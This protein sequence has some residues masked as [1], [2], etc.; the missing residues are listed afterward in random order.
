MYLHLVC[1]FKAC[2]VL[3]NRDQYCAVVRVGLHVIRPV[4]KVTETSGCDKLA[5][6]I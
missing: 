1:F 2:P 5:A 6:G 4:W 3:V